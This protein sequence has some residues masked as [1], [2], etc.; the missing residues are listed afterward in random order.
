MFKDDMHGAMVATVARVGLHRWLASC[1]G[2][3]ITI[4]VLIL[5]SIQ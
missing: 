3:F 5:V 1:S 2:F 4:Q